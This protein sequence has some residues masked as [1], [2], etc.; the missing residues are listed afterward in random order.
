MAARLPKCRNSL[1][2]STPPSGN[3][4][5]YDRMEAGRV[6]MAASSQN[7]IIVSDILPSDHAGFT[8]PFHSSANQGNANE[9]SGFHEAASRRSRERRRG[10]LPPSALAWPGQFPGQFWEAPI[11][12]HAHAETSHFD[13]RKL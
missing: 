4:W 13:F 6:F 1:G 7:L 8:D 2:D 5:A 11:I 9:V 10:G 12:V 3:D